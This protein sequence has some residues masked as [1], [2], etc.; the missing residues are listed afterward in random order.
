MLLLGE[1]DFCVSFEKHANQQQRAD[2]LVDIGIS[3]CLKQR[4]ES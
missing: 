4:Q 1:P 2:L 3:V